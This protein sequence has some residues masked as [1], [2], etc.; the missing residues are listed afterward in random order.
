VYVRATV[1]IRGEVFEVDEPVVLT[2]SK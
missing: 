2:I 1:T